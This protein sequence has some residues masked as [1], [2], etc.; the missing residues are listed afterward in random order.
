M[1]YKTQADKDALRMYIREIIVPQAKKET[2]YEFTLPLG[3]CFLSS[4]V[5]YEVY[6]FPQFLFVPWILF[7]IIIWPKFEKLWKH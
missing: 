2:F 7:W 4:F 1:E 3:M 5:Y 6:Q